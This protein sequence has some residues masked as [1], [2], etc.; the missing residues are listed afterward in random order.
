LFAASVTNARRA[1]TVFRRARRGGTAAE[2]ER[3]DLRLTLATPSPT[4]VQVATE[5]RTGAYA[6]EH[7]L[8]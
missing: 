4:C 3:D 7:Q 6:L 8:L 2:N 5:L 1:F